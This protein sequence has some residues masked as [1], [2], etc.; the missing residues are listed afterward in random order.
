[1]NL[2]EFTLEGPQ[3][4]QEV[5]PYWGC[6]LDV[7]R[8]SIAL[9]RIDAY[10]NEASQNYAILP[11]KVKAA[12]HWLRDHAFSEGPFHRDPLMGVE[13]PLVQESAVNAVRDFGP[14]SIY[15]EARTVENRRI[16]RL[17]DEGY[18]CLFLLT[19]REEAAWRACLRKR[20]I[21]ASRLIAWARP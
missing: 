11:E 5:A 14:Y 16:G 12:Q 15:C 9:V 1:M 21:D 10:P 8:G 17:A 7:F 18:D 13:V 6:F 20:G 2:L 19:S 4:S 3:S